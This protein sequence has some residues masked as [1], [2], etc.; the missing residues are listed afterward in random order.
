MQQLLKLL[1]E[2]SPSNIPTLKA[3]ATANKTDENSVNFATKQSTKEANKKRK[4]A[5]LTEH[6]SEDVKLKMKFG[7]TAQMYQGARVFAFED[8]EE[9]R[10]LR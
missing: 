6:K 8:S 4:R 2:N 1:E 3:K 10:A 5:A 7:L 9:V